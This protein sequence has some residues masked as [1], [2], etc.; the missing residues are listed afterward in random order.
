MLA[1]VTLLLVSEVCD[2]DGP[3]GGASWPKAQSLKPHK[4]LIIISLLM[5]EMVVIIPSITM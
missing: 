1:S 3:G 5:N 2:S 4:Y